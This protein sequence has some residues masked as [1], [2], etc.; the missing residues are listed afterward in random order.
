MDAENPCAGSA[1]RLRTDALTEAKK[2]WIRWLQGAVSIRREEKLYSSSIRNSTN[3][4]Q[5]TH[6]TAS[7]YCI[8]FFSSAPYYKPAGSYKPA[9]HVF[10]LTLLRIAV[11]GDDGYYHDAQDE[12]LD[13]CVQSE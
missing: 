1:L 6:R 13:E 10:Q 11:Q 8:Y 2:G 12:L 3:G 4:M 7:H 5:L 9:L